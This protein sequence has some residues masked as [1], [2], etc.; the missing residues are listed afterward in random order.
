MSYDFSKVNPGNKALLFNVCACASALGEAMERPQHLP[1]I[2]VFYGP[3]GFGKSSA[4]AVAMT[5]HNAY[6]VQ[7][8]SSWTRKALHLSILKSMGITPAKTVYDMG[9]QI[10][11]QL[12]A[13]GYPLIIDEADHLV[14]KGIIEV[15]RDIYEASQAT[16]ML[17]GEENLPAN[18]KKWERFHGRVLNWVPAAPASYDDAA[19][20]REKYATR[21][22]IADDL[23]AMVHEKSKGSVRRI[24][25]NLENIQ[26]T[27]LS[28]GLAAMNR[29]SWG[30]RDLFTGEAPRRRLSL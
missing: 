10:A 14:N 20:L 27:A 30:N 24:C 5:H 16:I 1:G 7:A 21:V 19:A 25:V 17:I 22:A 12:V 8:Q 11:T 3:S 28:K 26:R 15:I 2:V 23:L 13:S 6:Y 29:A 9:E 4:A 18:L